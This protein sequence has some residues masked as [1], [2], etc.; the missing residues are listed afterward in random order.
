[1]ASLRERVP[2]IR[3]SGPGT[4]KLAAQ[5]AERNGIDQVVC[6]PDWNRHGWAAPFRR[7]DEL[8]D[9][10]PRGVIVFPGNGSTENLV[11]K[12]VK[13]GIPVLRS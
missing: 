8:L 6:K 7:N 9:L 11:D 5:W 13:L 12:A 3:H 10:L 1:M 2:T 4:D